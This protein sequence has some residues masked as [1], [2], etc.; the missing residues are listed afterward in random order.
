[1]PNDVT[2]LSCQFYSSY[3]RDMRDVHIDMAILFSA[4]RCHKPTPP[5]NGQV[6]GNGFYFVGDIIKY[7]CNTGYRMTSGIRKNMCGPRGWVKEKPTCT[8]KSICTPKSICT[9]KCTCIPNYTYTRESTCTRKTTC[10]RKSIYT[11]KSICTRKSNCTRKST[12]IRTYTCIHKSTCTR[13]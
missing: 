11:R 4:T 7:S 9:H 2:V 8:R 5:A 10:T 12:Y 1:M 6:S 3:Y 13:K